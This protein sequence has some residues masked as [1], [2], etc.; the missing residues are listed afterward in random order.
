M[1]MPSDSLGKSSMPASHKRTNPPRSGFDRCFYGI[2][3]VSST[4]F[5]VAAEAG[6][7]PIACLFSYSPDDGIK[8]FSSIDCGSRLRRV[9]LLLTRARNV[10]AT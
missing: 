4:T 7:F 2:V 10:T 6:L 5:S 8:A 1:T 9:R 3:A